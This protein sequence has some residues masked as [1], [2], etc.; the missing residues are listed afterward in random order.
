MGGENTKREKGLIFLLFN[1]ILFLI[2][3]LSGQVLS[4]LTP[5]RVCFLHSPCEDRFSYCI[6]PV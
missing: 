4:Y 6:R 5:V 2:K 1:V 3:S